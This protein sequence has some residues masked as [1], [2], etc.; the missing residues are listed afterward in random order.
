MIKQDLNQK[1]HTPEDWNILVIEDSDTDLEILIEYFE[2]IG[3]R[4]FSSSQS[5]KTQ[6]FL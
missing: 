1:N 6:T 5:I 2:E 3:I 4:K